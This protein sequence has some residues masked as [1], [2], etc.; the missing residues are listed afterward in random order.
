LGQGNPDEALREFGIALGGRETIAGRDRNN[1]SWQ[2]ALALTHVAIAGALVSR[3]ETD[4]GLAEYQIA[5]AT[6]EPLAAN[7][8]RN[9]EFQKDLQSVRQKI[10][11]QESSATTSEPK[12]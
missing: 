4:R 5:L 3:G 12:P 7:E 1:A 9:A 2:R 8:P 6:L 10:K 11:E